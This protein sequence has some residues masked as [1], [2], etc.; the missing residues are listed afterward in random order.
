APDGTL[1][2]VFYEA[3]G[4]GTAAIAVARSSDRG[5]HFGAPERAASLLPLYYAT[6]TDSVTADSFPRAQGDPAGAPPIAYAPPRAPD[7]P[8]GSDVLYV[9][10]TAAGFEPPRRVDDDA[11]ATTQFNPSLAVAADGTVGVKWWDRRNDPAHDGLTDVYFAASHDGGATF[12]PNT[13]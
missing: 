3:L 5:V 2:I 1:A 10:S 13:R 6:R 7:S 12:D 11:T 9:R 8:D 4:D